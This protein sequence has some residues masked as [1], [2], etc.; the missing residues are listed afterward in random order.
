MYTIRTVFTNARSSSLLPLS[1]LH[2]AFA[3][4]VNVRST[5]TVGSSTRS[6]LIICLNNIYFY[7]LCVYVQLHSKNNK[8]TSIHIT[9]IRIKKQTAAIAITKNKSKNKNNT[10]KNKIPLNCSWCTHTFICIRVYQH[11][12]PT[13]K[14]YDTTNSRRHLA[15]TPSY[16]SCVSLPYGRI[17]TVRRLK[18]SSVAR[19]LFPESFLSSRNRE[20]FCVIKTKQENKIK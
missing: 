3:S 19:E 10:N 9:R 2:V 20:H 17:K 13:A 12:N 15:L 7:V 18:L 16:S 1:L 11:C 8:K 6:F 5:R 14:I 4:F